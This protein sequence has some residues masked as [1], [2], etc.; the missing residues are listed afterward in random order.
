MRI[1]SIEISPYGFDNSLMFEVIVV[2]PIVSPIAVVKT[3]ICK[4]GQS[5]CSD[6]QA[7][8]NC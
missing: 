3:Q 4:E 6:S 7:E 5:N 2:A 8:K 1:L